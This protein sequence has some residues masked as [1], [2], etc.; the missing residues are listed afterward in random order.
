MPAHPNR[1][2]TG[3]S[4]CRVSRLHPAPDLFGTQLWEYQSGERHGRIAAPMREIAA[5]LKVED[6]LAMA[7]Y[8]ASMPP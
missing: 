8:L 3:R 4:L 7:A 5:Q 2:P 1:V 6:M